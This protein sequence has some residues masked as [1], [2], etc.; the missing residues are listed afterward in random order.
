MKKYQIAEEGLAQMLDLEP[1]SG[2][3]DR[4]ELGVKE[5][6]VMWLQGDSAREKFIYRS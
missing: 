1:A 5:N 3:V 2:Q 6:C 4:S